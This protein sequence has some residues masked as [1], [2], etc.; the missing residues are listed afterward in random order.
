MATE[1][2][3]SGTGHPRRWPVLAVLAAVAFMAQLDLFI[4]NIAVPAMSRSFGGAGLSGLSWVLNAYA[5]VF[6][7]LLVPAGRLADHYGRRLFLLSGVVVFTLAS[8][9]CALA[10]TL[11][12]LVGG[13]AVQAVGAAMI[14][15]TSLG[16]LLPSFPPR[17]HTLVVGVWAGVAA[18]AASSGPPV[19][20]VLVAVDWRWIF[21]VNVP[22]GVVTVVAGLRVLPE[23]R[24]GR[25]ARLPDAVSTVSLL[26]AVTL[27]VLATVQGPAWGWGSAGVV[28]LLAAAALATVVT[29]RRS[30][31]HPRALVEA[32][33]FRGREFTGA[34]VA[35]LLFYVAFGAWLLITVL[36]LQD[37]WHYSALRAGVAIVPG[38][39][40][41]AA[42]AV[43]SGRITGRFGR[44]LPA[45]T[46]T[47]LLALAAV[48]WLVLAPAH[49]AYATHFLPGLFL[50]GAGAG[51]AQAPMFAAAGTLPPDRATTGSAV[52]NMSRQVGSAIGV[53]VLVA[54]L[55]APQPHA[56]AAFHRGW[57]LVAGAAL[58]AALVVTVTHRAAARRGTREPSAAVAPE[59][60][61]A[62]VGGG[63]YE[64]GTARDGD[65]YARGGAHESGTACGSGAP[66]AR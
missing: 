5:I 55:A 49:P 48:F 34:S 9:L 47:A 17:Q 22:I 46:G 39:L 29:V 13:R 15:P 14:V 18:V 51:L 16:L 58:G 31:R 37:V 6:A 59:P 41:S 25:G 53:A 23:I 42:F 44:V 61:R 40:T 30:L 50:G 12:V 62:A 38:P 2:T 4:V 63:A 1:A 54:L 19:G 65:T 57:A 24:A 3:R 26:A 32:S 11:P 45:A 60:E 7:A 28:G 35:L 36:F 56:L 27:L 66:A 20:G 21:L 8:V 64:S 33:L 52:L 10:P 43:N